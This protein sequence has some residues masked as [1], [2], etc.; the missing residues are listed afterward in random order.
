M[1]DKIFVNLPVADLPK[2][3]DFYNALGFAFN[4]Q[5]CDDTGACVVI[6]EHIY[7][8]LLTHAKFAEFT[9]KPI[10]DAKK[11][12]EVL[13]CLNCESRRHVDELVGKAVAAGGATYSEPKD[14]GF[15][16]AHGFADIDGH[17]WELIYMEPSAVQ[18]D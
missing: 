8:M 2:S 16:Y 18:Q 14:H 17:I 11:S 9:P 5:F 3:M 12:T 13:L 4:K 15:M 7:T 10:C 1:N 6:S